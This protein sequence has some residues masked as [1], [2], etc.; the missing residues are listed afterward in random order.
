MVDDSVL[1]QPV[2]ICHVVAA[3]MS[4]IYNKIIISECQKYEDLWNGGYKDKIK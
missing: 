2:G 3:L 4:N 1:L